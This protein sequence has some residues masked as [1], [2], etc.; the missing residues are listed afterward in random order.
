MAKVKITT[1]VDEQTAGVLRARSAQHEVSVSETVA[2]TLRNA[3]RDRVA[4]GVGTE[5]LLPAV[6]GAVRR[7]VARMSDRLAHLMARSA[8]E[9]AAGR[10][11]LYQL[12]VSEFGREEATEINRMAW[13]GSVE[14]LKKPAEGLRE[15]IGER[16]DEVSESGSSKEDES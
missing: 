4:E 16:F 2:E 14:G 5:L 8:L 6:R 3:V 13:T 10:R 7:E 12:L 15:I 11:A 1:W 9:S